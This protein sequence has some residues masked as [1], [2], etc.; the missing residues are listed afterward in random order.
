MGKHYCRKGGAPIGVM[1][2]PPYA[3]PGRAVV[4][5][6]AL[7]FGRVRHTW[8]CCGTALVEYMTD[9]DDPECADTF[10]L[11]VALG[12]LSPVP[13]GVPYS[14][15]CIGAAWSLWLPCGHVNGEGCDCDTIE[16][17]AG[18]DVRDAG[19]ADYGWGSEFIIHPRTGE[20]SPNGYDRVWER[21]IGSERFQFAA[22]PNAVTVR[23][24]SRARRRWEWERTLNRPRPVAYMSTYP[25]HGLIDNPATCP[26]DLV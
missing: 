7:E 13:D 2:W 12:L 4:D 20:H 21:V 16:A 1:D 14:V 6:T 9:A 19:E 17:E 25:R 18:P 11:P 10:T 3:D 22:C 8:R 5:G 15:P 24:W 26:L 23:R